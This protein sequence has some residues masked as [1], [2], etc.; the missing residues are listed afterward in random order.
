MMYTLSL[1]VNGISTTFDT[2]CGRNTSLFF[3]CVLHQ[4]KTKNRAL[5]ATKPHPF[6][7]SVFIS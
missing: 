5:A 3:F 7:F 4:Q 2:G 6:P 1:R